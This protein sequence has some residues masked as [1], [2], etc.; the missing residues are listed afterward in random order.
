MDV[1]G[2]WRM[3]L[4]FDFEDVADDENEQEINVNPVQR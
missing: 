4:P 1:N 2:T 3:D